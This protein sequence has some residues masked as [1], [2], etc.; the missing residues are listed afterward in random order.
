MRGSITNNI[1]Y[2]WVGTNCSLKLPNFGVWSNW[3]VSDYKGTT[4]MTGLVT[5]EGDAG[6][7]AVK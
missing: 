4:S 5:E 7:P 3:V 2:F 6:G 1:S